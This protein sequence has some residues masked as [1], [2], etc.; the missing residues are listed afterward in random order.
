MTRL[1][2]RP[3]TDMLCALDRRCCGSDFPAR[4]VNP[5][6]TRATRGREAESG[7]IRPR[8]F[9]FAEVA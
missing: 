8:G 9:W 7:P 5:S 2:N 6:A 1:Q 3:G 4:A